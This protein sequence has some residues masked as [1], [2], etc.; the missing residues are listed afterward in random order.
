MLTL[1]G[2]DVSPRLQA[3]SGTR[4]EGQVEIGIKGGHY[5]YSSL[6]HP[7]TP[8]VFVKRAP[9]HLTRSM[10]TL[11]SPE[12]G[13]YVYIHVDYPSTP[14]VLCHQDTTTGIHGVSRNTTVT[15]TQEKISVT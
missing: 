4:R 10:H 9:Q 14:T 11:C 13:W 6:L 7:S 12:Q 3:S 1:R 2:L 5:F 15:N 8:R